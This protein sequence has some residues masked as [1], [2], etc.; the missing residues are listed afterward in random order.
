MKDTISY[1]IKW[2]GS[3]QIHRIHKK[4]NVKQIYCWLISRDNK[5]P[6]VT[7][8]E[9]AWQFPGGKPENNE[10]T[11]ETIIREFDEELS[12][13]LVNLDSKPTFFGYYLVKEINEK[14]DIVNKYLQLRYYLK[15]DKSSKDLKIKPNENDEE[16]TEDKIISAKWV[17]LEQAKSLVPWLG[18]SDELKSLRQKVD[19]L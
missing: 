14:K 1:N 17:S 6:L 4:I 5:I 12:L 13:N 8:N 15:I 7:K 9:K 3:T 2:F 10:T 16:A 19:N 11:V 18:D